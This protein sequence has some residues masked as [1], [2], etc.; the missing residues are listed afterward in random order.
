MS[1]SAVSE[2][3]LAQV[4]PSFFWKAPVSF[5]IW[6]GFA[7]IIVPLVFVVHKGAGAIL[8]FLVV[9]N[10]SAAWWRCIATSLTITSRRTILRRGIFSKSTS[11]VPHSAVRQVI[12]RQSFAQRLFS[13]GYLAI[14][15]SAGSDIEIE[16]GGVRH[17]ERLK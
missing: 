7:L 12:L 16:I 15:S 14:N 2:S 11:E 5:L 4:H 17:P 3:T 1:N 13:V 8:G 10:A 6:T 9:T